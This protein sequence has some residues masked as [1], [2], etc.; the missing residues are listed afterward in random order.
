[1]DDDTPN[2]QAPAV[3]AT[4][5]VQPSRWL[6]FEDGYAEI[7]LRRVPVLAIDFYREPA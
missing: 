4:A 1:M 7:L 2:T 3:Q 5:I 6:V